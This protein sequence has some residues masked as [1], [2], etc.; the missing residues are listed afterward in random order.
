MRAGESA[1]MNWADGFSKSLSSIFLNHLG[2][3][4]WSGC[5]QGMMTVKTHAVSFYREVFGIEIAI[6]EY[7]KTYGFVVAL[8]LFEISFS[9]LQVKK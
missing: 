1:K 9:T 8:V 2:G 3:F 7:S 6:H 5:P 4:F